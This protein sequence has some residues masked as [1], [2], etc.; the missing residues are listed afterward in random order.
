MNNEPDRAFDVI[1][2]KAGIQCDVRTVETGVRRD[3]GDVRR[4]DVCSS[5][6]VA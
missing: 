1:P 2:A 4:N 5:G 6:G 3:D